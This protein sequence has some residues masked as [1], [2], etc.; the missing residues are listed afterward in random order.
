[1]I[2][3]HSVSPSKGSYKSYH[4]VP[5]GEGKKTFVAVNA[6]LTLRAVWKEHTMSKYEK[7]KIILVSAKHVWTNDKYIFFL[8]SLFK[9]K[10]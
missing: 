10:L 8:Q 4:M 3:E 1:M 7:K 2:Y 9:H 5:I 6:F